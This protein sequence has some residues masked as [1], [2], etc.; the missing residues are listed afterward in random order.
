MNGR[1]SRM[2]FRDFSSLQQGFS[3]VELMVAVVI[4]GILA[5]LAVPTYNNYTTKARI[6][7]ATSAL[8][9]KRMAME[10]YFQDNHTYVG[11][12]APGTTYPCVADN[13]SSPYFSFSCGPLTVST[14]TIMAQGK[15]TMAGFSYTIDNNNAKGTAI[16]P[17]AP[18]NWLV[19]GAN[20]WITKPGGSC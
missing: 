12:D 16:G 1:P 4:I 17:P 20:C 13:S 8:S 19:S 15:G 3:L 10:Q 14:Y 6:P 7:D 9:T 11:A 2:F 5:S 18:S